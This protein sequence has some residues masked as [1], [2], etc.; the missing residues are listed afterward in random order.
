[1][2]GR[3]RPIEQRQ[4]EGDGGGWVG[5]CARVCVSVRLRVCVRACVRDMFA[6]Y[7]N[8]I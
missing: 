8:T 7:D 2:V 3:H 5:A 1:M 6:I 4:P